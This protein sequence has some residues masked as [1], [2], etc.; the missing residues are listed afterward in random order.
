M[1]SF[2]Y[3]LWQKFPVGAGYCDLPI[4][5]YRSSP[6]LGELLKFKSIQPGC[7]TIRVTLY[8]DVKSAIKPTFWKHCKNLLLSQSRPDIFFHPQPLNITTF[9]EPLQTGLTS[10]AATKTMFSS[11]VALAVSLVLLAAVTQMVSN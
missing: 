7:T 1:H 8:S 5:G 6:Q 9:S 11:T 2:R 3:Q 10:G 4:D